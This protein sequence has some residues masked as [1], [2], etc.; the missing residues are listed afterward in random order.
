[1]RYII[2]INEKQSDKASTLVD[3]ISQAK[4]LKSYYNVEVKV[5]DT[6][7]SEYIGF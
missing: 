6:F 2:Y 3:A 5:Y 1:M 4:L 7:A